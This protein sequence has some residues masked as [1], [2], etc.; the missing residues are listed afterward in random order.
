MGRKDYYIICVIGRKSRIAFMILRLYPSKPAAESFRVL[1][2]G[3]TSFE[4]VGAKNMQL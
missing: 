3:I 1:M 2:V 4:L